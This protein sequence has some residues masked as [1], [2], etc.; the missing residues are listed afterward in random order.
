[1]IL[2]PFVSGCIASWLQYACCSSSHLDF[3]QDKQKEKGWEYTQEGKRT[4][5]RM[6][7]SKRWPLNFIDQSWSHSH[8]ELPGHGNKEQRLAQSCKWPL[9]CH[10]LLLTMKTIEL[11]LCPKAAGYS[12]DNL[13]PWVL[14]SPHVCLP[15]TVWG[16]LEVMVGLGINLGC[17]APQDCGQLGRLWSP[18]M[19]CGP[20]TPHLFPLGYLQ[21]TQRTE[22]FLRMP[23]PSCGKVKSWKASPLFQ[24]EQV[25]LRTSVAKNSDF[26]T[27]H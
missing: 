17:L 11:G 21:L 22:V 3:I 12:M 14:P 25:C 15:E 2:L 18:G 1:M 13:V 26:G 7:P 4:L 16:N 9:S 23:L 6:P 8:P 24:F 27:V 20:V 10:E 19:A 5:L